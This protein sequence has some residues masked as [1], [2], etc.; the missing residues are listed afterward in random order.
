MGYSVGGLGLGLL[1]ANGSFPGSGMFPT[2]MG[3][4]YSLLGSSGWV[5]VGCWLVSSVALVV[6]MVP[7]VRGGGSGR[8]YN[9]RLVLGRGVVLM[10][11]GC[12]CGSGSW[13]WVTLGMFGSGF[14]R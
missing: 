13:G 14:D 12:I 6:S 11:C 4:F 2:E 5:V 3:S 8:A 1:C 9:S 7:W 10:V